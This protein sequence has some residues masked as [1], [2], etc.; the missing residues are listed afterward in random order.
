VA[1]TPLGGAGNAEK[2]I[3]TNAAGVLDITLFPAGIGADIVSVP[4]SESLAAGAVVNLFTNAGATN[5][6]NADGS[7]ASGGK[8]VS[9]FVLSAVASGATAAVY[10]N[11]LNTSQTGLTPGADY[12]LATTPGGITLTPPTTAGQTQQYVGTAISA[13]SIDIQPAPFVGIA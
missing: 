7:V 5:A 3:S 8:K 12:Y 2:V 9:G 1:A 6:R 13:T 10:R 4:A 11:G